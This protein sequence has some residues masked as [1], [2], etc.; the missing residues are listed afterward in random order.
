MERRSGKRHEFI[1]SLKESSRF[2]RRE[3]S[4]PPGLLRQ[5]TTAHNKGN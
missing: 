2:L 5:E 4:D 1:K 3:K